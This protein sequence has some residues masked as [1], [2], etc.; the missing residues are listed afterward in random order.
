MNLLCHDPLK[1]T[2]PVQ[3]SYYSLGFI[4]SR[5]RGI[6]Q[7]TVSPPQGICQFHL[8]KCLCPRVS[9]G[10]GGGMG[11]GGI[12]WCITAT[13]WGQYYEEKWPDY[14]VTC[15]LKF[16]NKSH[17]CHSLAVPVARA[18]HVLGL[19]C[20]FSR[21]AK[22]FCCP[23]KRFYTVLSNPG[24]LPG[25]SIAGYNNFVCCLFKI[26]IAILSWIETWL[27]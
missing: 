7:L 3:V 25:T 19:R 6:C 11:T 23:R 22:K 26:I 14:C 12:D 15:F 24:N 1:R 13:V 21:K 10:G 8:K 16:Y 27:I 20:C 2:L 18:N 5:G 17:T 4:R 9:P